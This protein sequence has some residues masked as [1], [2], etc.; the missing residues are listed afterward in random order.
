MEPER[1]PQPRRSQATPG[2]RAGDEGPGWPALILRNPTLPSP[3]NNIRASVI[4]RTVKV[5]QEELGNRQL[6]SKT[7][8]ETNTTAFHRV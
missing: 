8:S 1:N 5:H 4:Y 7:G 3:K 6:L 2:V